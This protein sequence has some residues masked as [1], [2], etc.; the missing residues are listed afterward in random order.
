MSKSYEKRIGFGHAHGL[1]TKQKRSNVRLEKRA[2]DK[3]VIRGYAAVFYDPNAAEETEYWLWDDIV[4]RIAK[5]AFDRAVKEAHDVRG[6]FN[7]DPSILLGRSSSG[8]CRY[9][10]DDVGLWYEIDAN[11]SDP[12]WQRVAS[13]IDRGDITGSSFAFSAK[14]TV[15]IEE[16]N[17]LVR[18]I[19]D[20]DLFDVCPVTFPAYSGTTAGRSTDQ[21]NTQN[22]AEREALLAEY[23]SQQD[24]TPMINARLAEIGQELLR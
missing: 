3:S 7:H 4:E 10:V 22:D 14:R 5:G 19:Q 24:D 16:E 8:T 11:V 15:W 12:D 13:K 1:A 20:L 23:R 6:L 18:E 17:Y 9:G 21:R 2:D